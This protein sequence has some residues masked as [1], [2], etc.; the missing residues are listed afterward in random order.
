MSVP[1][2]DDVTEDDRHGAGLGVEVWTLLDVEVQMWPQRVAGVSDR[3]DL[4]TESHALALADLG[5]SFLEVRQDGVAVADL[6]N[7]VVARGG[8][9]PVLPMGSSG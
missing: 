2:E 7:D 6:E 1:G 8:V 4:L 3:S 9:T 5:A